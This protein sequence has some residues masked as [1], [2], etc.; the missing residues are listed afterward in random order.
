[1]NIGLR[2]FFVIAES[3]QRKVSLMINV[4]ACTHPI[5]YM[6][7]CRAPDAMLTKR[8][9]NVR[10]RV[11]ASQKS[12]IAIIKPTVTLTLV[13]GLAESKVDIRQSI[14]VSDEWLLK[15]KRREKNY[16]NVTCISWWSS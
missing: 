7:T 16:K 10:A 3:L 13:F 12:Q 4:Q 6:N 15:E 8:F 11:R 2:A 1:M 9:T 14:Q 5:V